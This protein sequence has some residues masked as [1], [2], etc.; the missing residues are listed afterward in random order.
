MT[1]ESKEL[2][3]YTTG[4]EPFGSEVSELQMNFRRDLL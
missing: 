1:D 4:I 2:Y 3:N